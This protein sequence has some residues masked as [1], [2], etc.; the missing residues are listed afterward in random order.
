[1]SD[2]TFSPGWPPDQEPDYPPEDPKKGEMPC[3]C[4]AYPFPHRMGGGNCEMPDWC[5][6]HLTGTWED[7]YFLIE[8]GLCDTHQ[9]GPEPE[10][11][12]THPSLTNG[13]RNR[14][15]VLPF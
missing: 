14:G 9:P 6:Q 1:M 2:P 13:E 3:L 10:T 12:F 5:G 7:C 11:Y 8:D 15:G 4:F